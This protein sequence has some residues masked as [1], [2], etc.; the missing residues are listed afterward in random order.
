MPSPPPTDPQTLLLTHLSTKTTHL[1]DLHQSLLSSLQRTGWTE[2]VRALATELLRAGRA[3][4]FEEVVG[5]VVG[6]VVKGGAGVNG[7]VNGNGNGN[8]RLEGEEEGE[9][10]DRDAEGEEEE[11]GGYVNG[12]GNNGVGN[13]TTTVLNGTGTGVGISSWGGNIEDIDV[14]I[15]E[16]VVS[17]GMRFLQEA[18]DGV[19]SSDE[20]SD[21]EGEDGDGEDEAVKLEKKPPPPPTEK[22][23]NG[24]RGRENGDTTAEKS[25]TA[26]KVK[27]VGKGG[28]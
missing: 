2:R 26:K 7:A 16:S 22:S 1:T 20:E 3:E 13:T 9:E 6:C 19:L 17:E 10:E 12:N 23:T 14:R 28:K 21:G 27:G 5:E 15:P 11:D 25:G 8:G 4:T 18:L 24:K